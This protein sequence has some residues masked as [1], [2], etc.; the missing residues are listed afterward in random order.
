MPTDTVKYCLLTSEMGD[1]NTSSTG[2]LPLVDRS[3]VAICA[4]TRCVRTDKQ[5]TLDYC[6]VLCCDCIYTVFKDFVW[7]D[8]ETETKQ[9]KDRH[10]C[11]LFMYLG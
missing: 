6:E 9:Y 3:T 1:I 5:T 7:R 10:P 2:A 8:C 4:L 11:I